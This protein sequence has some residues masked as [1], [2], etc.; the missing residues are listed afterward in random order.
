MKLY[1]FTSTSFVIVHFMCV[2]PIYFKL[3]FLQGKAMRYRPATVVC[4]AVPSSIW[5]L[6]L[7][8]SL[9]WKWYVIMKQIGRYEYIVLKNISI[10]S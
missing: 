3:V 8:L 4:G 9:E 7:S 5:G 6:C 1:C 10:C 2:G